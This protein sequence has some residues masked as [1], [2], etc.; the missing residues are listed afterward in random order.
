MLMLKIIFKNLKNIILIYF[1]I[2]NTLKNNY[3]YISKHM[4]DQQTIILGQTSFDEHKP[5]ELVI[6][7]Q[8]FLLFYVLVLQSTLDI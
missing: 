6:L 8:F 4:Q 2:K 3:Y 7:D 5:L 1:K